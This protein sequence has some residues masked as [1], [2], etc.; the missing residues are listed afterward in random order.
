MDSKKH[1]KPVAVELVING[2]SD[3]TQL[4]T[5][6]CPDVV[7]YI[8]N[9]DA[10][11]GCS[12]LERIARRVGRLLDTALCDLALLPPE[13]RHAVLSERGL[14]ATDGKMPGPREAL[15]RFEYHG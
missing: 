14:V 3:S 2:V 5:R 8:V 7:H 12:A 9:E 1:T 6:E 4:L 10:L 15:K 11:D 13:Q